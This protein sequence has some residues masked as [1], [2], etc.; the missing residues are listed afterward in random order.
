[1][2][3][4]CEQS[5]QEMEM[6]L[7]KKTHPWPYRVR[8]ITFPLIVRGTSKSICTSYVDGLSRASRY[9]AMSCRS[10]AFPVRE[11]LHMRTS[12]AALRQQSGIPLYIRS[13]NLC[14]FEGLIPQKSMLP[15]SSREAGTSIRLHLAV[16]KPSL[17]G[18]GLSGCRGS[19]D[20]LAG[21]LVTAAVRCAS[22]RRRC[23][24]GMGMRRSCEG[25][26]KKPYLRRRQRRA[27]SKNCRDDARTYQGSEATGPPAEPARATSRARRPTP[28]APEFRSRGCPQRAHASVLRPPRTRRP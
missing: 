4:A 23:T 28:V 25:V 11:N 1:M 3:A 10:S 8:N 21:P 17:I 15:P 2:I 14:S 6:S 7:G 26:V 22:G 5:Q 20:G 16:R 12:Q 13:Q 18:I 24:A 9:S 19:R 27:Q